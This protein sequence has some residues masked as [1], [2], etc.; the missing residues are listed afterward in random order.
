MVVVLAGGMVISY[1][2]WLCLCSSD[3]EGNNW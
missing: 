2:N 3:E 1:V